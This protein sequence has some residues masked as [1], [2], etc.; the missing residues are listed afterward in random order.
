MLTTVH[1]STRPEGFL[2]LDKILLQRLIVG[3]PTAMAAVSDG[4]DSLNSC[5]VEFLDTSD[6]VTTR[7]DAGAVS[8]NKLT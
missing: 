4:S 6:K 3:S 1:M 8:K 2:D 5:I 7:D